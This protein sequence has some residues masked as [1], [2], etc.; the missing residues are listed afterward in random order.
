[1]ITVVS[2]L[3]LLGIFYL[4]TSQRMK[5]DRLAM[6]RSIVDAASAIATADEAAVQAGRLSPQQARHHAAEAIRAIRYQGSEYIWINDMT[7]RMVMHP[8]RP[9]LE[10]KD[11]RNLADPTGFHLFNAFVDKVRTDGAG[12]VA[13]LWPR[14]GAKEP[15]P[16]MSYVA[17][18]KPWGWVIGS[19]VYVDDLVA[20]RQRLALILG[21]IGLAVSLVIGTVIFILGR[22]IAGPCG[23]LTI[24]MRKL[25][26]G[27]HRVDIPGRDRKDELGIMADAVLI[28]RDGARHRAELERQVAAER[29][30]RD[31]RQLAMEHHARDFNGSIAGVMRHL[32]D[33][34]DAMR[35]ATRRVTDAVGKTRD[36]AEA[37]SAGAAASSANLSSVASAAEEMSASINE[38]NRQVEQVTTAARDA[39]EKVIETDAR[40]GSLVEAAD[41][42]GNVVSLITSIAAQTNL[43]ALNATIEAARAGEAGRGFAVVAGEVKALAAQTATATN[44]IRE[45]ID[46]IRQATDSAAASVHAVSGS[47]QQMNTIAA[48]IGAA[49]SEQA[50]ATR[51]IA[52]SVQVVSATT[53]QASMAMREVCDAVLDAGD[54][55]A[56]VSATSDTVGDT[57]RQLTTEMEL[58]LRVLENPD[59]RQRRRYERKPGNG[60]RLTLQQGDRS[61]PGLEVKDL[62]RGG[63]ALICEQSFPRGTEVMIS[64]PDLPDRL[65]ARVAR[66]EPGTV[67]LAYHQEEAAQSL[68][69]LLVEKAAAQRRIAA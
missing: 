10:G 50:G 46:A 57:A 52:G 14:P 35:A 59:E 33:S 53:N 31:N 37:T 34:A 12:M 66:C 68:A 29:A 13:Y 58:F 7:P 8:F 16:K 40:V 38:I 65:Q 4:I 60:L 56:L 44:E 23:A 3:G 27:D 49:V 18:F 9:D 25:A 48:A 45:Q 47:V 20:Q 62:S 51:E 61:W 1:A 41:R 5:D 43:L 22:G 63:I 67:A 42:I 15:V 54:A 69:D 30:A 39:A 28:L 26:D 11:L 19:G 55:S 64:T 36:R 17:G 32:T 21:G 6:L 2:F 24:A